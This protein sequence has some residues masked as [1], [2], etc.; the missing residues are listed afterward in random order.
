M[1][2]DFSLETWFESVIFKL[3]KVKR[4]KKPTGQNGN[5]RK[6]QIYQSSYDFFFFKGIAEKET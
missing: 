3:K 6:F 5:G 4:K 1:G 2:D